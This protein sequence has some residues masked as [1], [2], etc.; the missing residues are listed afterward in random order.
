M[1]QPVEQP[2]HPARTDDHDAV[3]ARGRAPSDDCRMSP[4][5][6]FRET[7]SAEWEPSAPDEQA[8]HTDNADCLADYGGQMNDWEPLPELEPV[9]P[10]IED[11]PFGVW[12]PDRSDIDK[13]VFPQLSVTVLSGLSSGTAETG[14]SAPNG[15]DAGEE[16]P[17]ETGE[18]DTE[19]VSD[20]AVAK[21]LKKP[22]QESIRETGEWLLE[23]SVVFAAHCI[24]P[25]A[26]HLV[27]I[28]FEAKGVI[29]DAAALASP[30]SP[31]ELHVPLVHLPPGFE[32]EANVQLGSEADE[33]EPRLSVFVVPG[34]GGLFGGWALERDEDQETAKQAPRATEQ[35]ESA[36][37]AVVHANLS[38]ATAASEEPRARAAILRETAYRLQSEL[39]DRPEYSGTSLMVIYDDQADL[40]MWLARSEAACSSRKMVLEQ[41]AETGRLVVRLVA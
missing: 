3:P 32:L 2:W 36:E 26:G 35:D 30:D 28:A 4:I 31:R 37:A 12:R 39:W 18:L 11:T 7:S 22:L 15:P 8:D 16:S 6:G 21:S 10:E 33:G 14:E 1:S 13:P 27:T 9:G 40:G 29:D 25:P 23:T 5:G 41:D 38:A 20:G 34:D 17:D 19:T 24:C